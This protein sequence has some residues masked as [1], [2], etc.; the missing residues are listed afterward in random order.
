LLGF[1]EFINKLT[2]EIIVVGRTASYGSGLYDAFLVKYNSLPGSFTLSADSFNLMWSA[3]T[4]AKNY[5]IYMHKRPIIEINDNILLPANN[6]IT[7]Q[8][9][10]VPALDDGIYYFIIIAYNKFGNTTSNYIE[11]CIYFP[12]FE[13]TIYYFLFTLIIIISSV[14]IGIEILMFILSIKITKE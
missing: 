8:T 13:N 11:I 4:D 5:S 6:N 14:L 9:Y 1:L 2:G 7:A 10:T 12:Y 3:S